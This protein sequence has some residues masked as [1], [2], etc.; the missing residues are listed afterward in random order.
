MQLN[1]ERAQFMRKKYLECRVEAQYK[2]L[3][4]L[5][6]MRT[7]HLNKLHALEWDNQIL[8]SKKA[9]KDLKK[10][11]DFELKQQPKSLR[12]SCLKGKVSTLGV[13]YLLH[14]S[15]SR[16]LRSSI[17]TLLRYSRK[18]TSLYRSS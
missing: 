17:T 6:N 8:S 14:R 12:V 4:A 11:H 9:E 13:N 5:H 7:E 1:K 15:R 10:K 18:N 3:K 2:Q 16:R